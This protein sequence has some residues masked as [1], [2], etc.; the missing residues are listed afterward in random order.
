M[1]EANEFYEDMRSK[2]QNVLSWRDGS[3]GTGD[4]MS[5]TTSESGN[6]DA[7]KDEV[8]MPTK[9]GT[10]SPPGKDMDLTPNG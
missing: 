8:E 1:N 3:N 7:K 5:A 6:E 2:H 9:D 10:I 4:Q